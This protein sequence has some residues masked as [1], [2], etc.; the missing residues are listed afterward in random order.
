[1]AFRIATPLLLLLVVGGIVVVTVGVFPNTADARREFTQNEAF[2]NEDYAEEG[3][4]SAYEGWEDEDGFPVE[5]VRDEE[6]DIDAYEWFKVHDVDELREAIGACVRACM[7]THVRDCSI[8]A[9]ACAGR[10]TRISPF[11]YVCA[12]V[13][14][15]VCIFL[16]LWAAGNGTHTCTA[17]RATHVSIERDIVMEMPLY[18]APLKWYVNTRGVRVSI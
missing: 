15:C 5:F 14:V 2:Y 7:H 12:C 8:P 18:D 3:V 6:D 17:K 16:S 4:Q 13:C 1:M 11:P 10:L 9:S